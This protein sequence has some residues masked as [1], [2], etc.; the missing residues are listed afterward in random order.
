MNNK[1]EVAKRILKNMLQ[2]M[3]IQDLLDY[4]NKRDTNLSEVMTNACSDY[5]VTKI[6]CRE[7][8]E[9]FREVEL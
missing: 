5:N 9:Y 1:K 4:Y 8:I 6:N 7:L 2:D 3:T